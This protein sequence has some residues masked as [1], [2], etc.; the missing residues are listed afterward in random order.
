MGGSCRKQEAMAVVEPGHPSQSLCLGCKAVAGGKGACS[1]G[2]AGRAAVEGAL[3]C[4]HGLVVHTIKS[5]TSC[6]AA[7]RHVT[8][9]KQPGK[10][11]FSEKKLIRRCFG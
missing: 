11:K 9:L 2:C 7:N 6:A 5:D 3:L 10:K 1:R 8:N 4:L